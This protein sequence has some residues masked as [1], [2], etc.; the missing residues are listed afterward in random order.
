MCLH[1]CA[2]CNG[3]QFDHHQ[4]CQYKNRMKEDFIKYNL[5]DPLFTV[6]MIPTI[7]LKHGIYKHTK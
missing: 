2:T 1:T 4:V 5:T 7:M 6:P 3:L